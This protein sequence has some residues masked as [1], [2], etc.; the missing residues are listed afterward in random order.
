MDLDELEQRARALLPADVYDYIAGGSFDEITLDD[1]RTAWDRI[2]LRPRV[3]RDVRTVTTATTVLGV[4]LAHPIVV[5][6]T[7]FHRMAHDDGEPATAS[8]AADAGAL[9]TMST[10]STA[11]IEDVAGALEGAPWWFQVYVLRDRETTD[12]LV[13]R[14]V[15]SGCGALVLTGD[16]PV[17]GRRMRDVRNRFVLPS[18]LGTIESLDRPGNLAD[19]DPG[20]TFDDIAWL[21][22]RF[23]LPVVVKGVLRGDDAV[24]CLEAGAAAVWV[25]NHGGRQLDGTIATAAALSDVVDAVGTRAEVYVDGGVRRGTDVLKALA[26][27][28]AAVMIGRPVVWGLA[29]GGRDGVREVLAALAAELE[30][31][32]ALAGCASVADVTPDLIA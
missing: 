22:D 24:R 23:G 5:A 1:N 3:L 27:G 11:P 14:A 2:R 19:Q 25:S 16:T 7:A 30:L 32:M 8:G 28:A 13:G 15:A 31:A 21:R 6:P 17:L 12:R 4:P 18:N 20:L 10:R 9:F 29:V 26:L